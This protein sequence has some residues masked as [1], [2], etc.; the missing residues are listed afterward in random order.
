MFATLREFACV[1]ASR[2]CVK[3]HGRAR[4]HSLGNCVRRV[5]ARGRA[6][7]CVLRL[8]GVRALFAGAPDQALGVLWSVVHCAYVCVCVF[9]VGG[10]H[11]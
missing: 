11:V 5:F 10:T 6:W 9:G 8:A 2:I 4:A 3:H 7:A 1:S